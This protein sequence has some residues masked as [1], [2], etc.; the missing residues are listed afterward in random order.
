M[1]SY[2]GSN[3][4][5]SGSTDETRN[6][7]EFGGRAVASVDRVARHSANQETVDDSGNNSRSGSDDRA[8]ARRAF[9]TP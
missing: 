9:P 7:G 5:A 8:S 1:E 4:R 2:S 3:G 6:E